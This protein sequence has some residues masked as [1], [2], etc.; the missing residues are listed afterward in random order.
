M[1]FSSF[2]S[3][4]AA[5]VALIL[6]FSGTALAQNPPGTPVAGQELVPTAVPS[7]PSLKGEARKA[8]R[9]KANAILIRPEFL[10]GNTYRFV[11]RTE[12]K[13]SLGGAGN[14]VIEQQA[15]FDTGV[16]V[17]GKNGVVVKARTERLD[18]RLQ[19]GGRTL[20][21]NS[22]NPEDQSTLMGR[23]F[24]AALYRSVDFTLNQDLRVASAEEGGRAIPESPLP[25]L[26]RFGPD[27]LKQLISTIPQGFS[28]DPVEP[29]ESWVL[30]GSRSVGE[31]GI[32]N[33]EIT[34]RLTGPVNFEDNNCL[35][36]EFTG[37]LSGEVPLPGP[38]GNVSGVGPMGLQGTGMSGRIFFDPLDK[39]VRYSEQNIELILAIPGPEGSVPQPV[40]V[41]QTTTIR[42]LHVVATP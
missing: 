35:G 36:I 38:D 1:N 11:T 33:F 17:D 5:G 30:Q 2:I 40:P 31:T 34:Y 10:P 9:S 42:L 37:Q 27:E 21:Y 13:T 8:S 26:P 16:R 23:H 28:N 15:R 7:P 32:L 29:G 4:F 22:L 41:Q 39:M 18:M 19:S 20:V 6:L 25:G 3:R 14:V 24:Q 12:L